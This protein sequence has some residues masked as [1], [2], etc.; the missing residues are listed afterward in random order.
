MKRI[1]KRIT[2][3][4]AVQ[5]ML[6]SLHL[7]QMPMSMLMLS[8]IAACGSGGSGGGSD[9][10]PVPSRFNAID[11]VSE[12]DSARSVTTAVVGT[13]SY[14]FAAGFDD[15]GVSVFSVGTAGRLTAAFHVTDGG[16]LELDGA[17]SVTTA[18]IAGTT[19]LFVAGF[20]DDGVSVF[21]VANNGSLT[22][23]DNVTDAGAL[24]LDG[25]VSVTTAVVG[26]TTYLF[27][28]GEADNG[29]SVFSVA[30]NGS[31]TSV[32][33]VADNSRVLEL[34]G[35]RSVTTAVVGSTTYLFVAGSAD[36]GVSVF[37]VASNGSLTSVFN[38]DETADAGALELLKPRSVTTAVVGSTTYLFV[39]GYGD[40]GV[41]VFSVGADGSLTSVFNVTDTSTLNLDGARSVTTAV[42]GSTTYLFVAGELDNGVSV[43]SVGADGS[44]TSVFNVTDAAASALQLA[45]AASVTT[46]VVG[47]TTYLF[48]AGITDNGVSV[49]SV[50]PNTGTLTSTYN[51]T[52]AGVLELDG[53]TSVTT[54]VVGTTTYFFV[55][56]FFDDGVSVFSVGADGSLATVFNVTDAGALELDGAASVTTAVV[57][58]TTY[59][60]VAGQL[61]NGVSVFSV[62]NT[63]SLTSVFNIEDTPGTL[64][65]SRAASVATAVVGTTTYL[66]VA[67]RVDDSVTVFSV[68]NNGSLT[69]V[70]TQ[71]NRADRNLKLNGATSVT[72]AVV[73]TTTYLFV[74]GSEDDG[75]SVFSVANNGSLTSVFNIDD[76]SDSALE[77]DGAASVATALV[78]TTTYLFV[79]GEA[80]DGVSVFSVAPNTG[81]LTS[82][83]NVADAGELELDGARSVTTATAGAATYLFVAGEADDGVSV[84]SVG[85]DG[86]LASVANIADTGA[87]NLDGAASVT[88][89]VVG[90]ETYLLV[91]G[92]ADDGVSVFSLQSLLQ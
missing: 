30:S 89:A 16:A 10:L 48:V 44:L 37:S 53:A 77:L 7:L 52:D 26:S 65:L 36:N 75:V 72:T 12:L 39:A 1:T 82:V 3:N 27:V 54:A 87:M 63:G 71:S 18:V 85:A 22:S 33:N 56:G 5:N 88:T 31:L 69:E 41:S 40:D 43:F 47:T 34:A 45:A 50:A 81:R 51:Q 73:G 2:K 74:A 78:G 21:S 76:A 70:D 68:A 58:S 38:I 62:A 61:D 92:E 84:F 28:A 60:F 24:E 86:S 11:D 55:A 79:A 42:V 91:A 13:T 35:A 14:L 17:T 83:F 80:D 57:G 29:V 19:Y 67:S 8:L 49:F 9:R 4:I 59:L 23:A 20:V 15:D 66:F 46:A 90:G 6:R 64:D 25:A 32:F